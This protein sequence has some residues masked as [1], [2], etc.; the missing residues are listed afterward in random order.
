[1]IAEG[2]ET[3]EQL[4]MLEKYGCDEIQGYL[5]SKQ[6]TSAS[7]EKFLRNKRAEPNIIKHDLVRLPTARHMPADI[8][9][10]SSWLATGSKPF[11]VLTLSV[12]RRFC[13]SEP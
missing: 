8:K 2:V 1:M 6:I 11:L 4:A 3:Q 5:F 10:Y 13:L 7:L 9:I 12:A